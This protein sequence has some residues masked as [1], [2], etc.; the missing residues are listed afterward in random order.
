MIAGE[1][2]KQEALSWVGTPFRHNQSCKQQGADCVGLVYGTFKAL[3][4]VPADFAPKPYSQQWHIHKNEEL[5]LDQAVAFGCVDVEG[6]PQ[7]GDLLFFQYGRVC[8]HI[9]IYIGNSEM[10]HAF[11]G[12]Q[13][14]VRQPLTGDLQKRLKRVMR[15]PWVA[16]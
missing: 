13:T 7:M 9:G 11:Y 10:V 3:G 4:C 6:E 2:V 16:E 15:T 12:L 14:A 1:R 8:S 5:L